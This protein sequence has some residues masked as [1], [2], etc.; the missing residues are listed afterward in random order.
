MFALDE[1]VTPLSGE[2]AAKLM[3]GCLFAAPAEADDGAPWHDPP[4]RCPTA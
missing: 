2:E 1:S 4:C 3:P